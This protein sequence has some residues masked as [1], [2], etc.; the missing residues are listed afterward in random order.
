MFHVCNPQGSTSNSVRFREQYLLAAS[1]LLTEPPLYI[2]AKRQKHY[3]DAW[4]PYFDSVVSALPALTELE[5]MNQ[6]A[7]KQISIESVFDRPVIEG[8]FNKVPCL[9]RAESWK[10]S[11]L[12]SLNA[13]KPFH[14]FLT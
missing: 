5:I 1:T 12:E 2:T 10:E 8:C 7:T 4:A 14:T 13:I 11:C 9:R 3:C 6:L